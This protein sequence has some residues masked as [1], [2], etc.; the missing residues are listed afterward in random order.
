MT[1]SEHER[2]RRFW[3]WR[4][5]EPEWFTLELAAH[6][7]S[8]A[9]APAPQEGCCRARPPS[10]RQGRGRGGYAGS[11]AGRRGAPHGPVPGRGRGRGSECRAPSRARPQ[12][13]PLSFASGRRRRLLFFPAL[14]AG[15]RGSTAAGPARPVPFRPAAAVAAGGEGCRRR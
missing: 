11:R 1:F 15:E 3:N 6:A 14:P 4:A 7:R 10:W 12:I 9:G 8:A 5:P 13:C 2:S